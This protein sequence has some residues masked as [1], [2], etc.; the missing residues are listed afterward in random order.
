MIRV[1]V[2]PHLRTL[3]KINGEV[4]LEVGEPGDTALRPGCA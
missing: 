1:V 2:P 4:T 3:A